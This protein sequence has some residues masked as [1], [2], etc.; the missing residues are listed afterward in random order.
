[1]KTLQT[2]V[3]N[4]PNA[5]SGFDV[6]LAERGGFSNAYTAEDSVGRR[7][8]QGFE[9]GVYSEERI[10]VCLIVLCGLHRLVL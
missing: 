1:M 6:W 2:P 7:L 10:G 5:R 8:L 3:T 9:R 4:S